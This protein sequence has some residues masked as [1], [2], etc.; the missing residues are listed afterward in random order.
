MLAAAI[1]LAVPLV[2]ART[3]EPN[4]AG[5]GTHQQLG[6][7]P[8]TVRAIWAIRCPACGMT[9]SWSHFVRGQLAMSLRANVAGTLLALFAC[10]AIV[11]LAR[12]ALCGAVP[13]IGWLVAV[14]WGMILMLA[15]ALAQWAWRLV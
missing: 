3:L 11:V 9:T 14:A 5:L 12:A 10:T 1:L 6:F 2:V 15:V 4:P 7:P 13:Q 8:C